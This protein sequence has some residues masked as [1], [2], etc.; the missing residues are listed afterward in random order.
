[1]KQTQEIQ[2]FDAVNQPLK[3]GVHLVEA[4]AGTGKTYAIAML[5]LRFIAEREL[6]IDR[7]LIVTYTRAATAELRARVRRR[8]VEGWEILSGSSGE[9]DPT[10]TA[11]AQTIPETERGQICLRLRLAIA[12]IDQAAIFTIHGFCQRM[13]MERA[14][15]SGGPFDAELVTDI[16]PVV[17]EVADDFWRECLYP[18]SGLLAAAVRREAKAPEQLLAT[19]RRSLRSGALLP[20]KRK[21]PA[22]AEAELDAEKSRFC[23]WWQQ[24]RDR[25]SRQ[26]EE[27]EAAGFFNAA[28]RDEWRAVGSACD[29]MA[30]GGAIPEKLHLFSAESLCDPGTK[31]LNRRRVKDAVSFCRERIFP[32]VEQLRDGERQLVLSVRCDLAGRLR[33]GVNR[34]LSERGWLSFDALINNLAEALQ[35]DDGRLLRHGLSQRFGAA[36]I[37]EFQDTDGEQYTIFSTLFGHGA[38]HLFL[39]GDPKQAIY[40]FRGADIHS[41]FAARRA[42]DTLLTLN[43]NYR[44]HPKVTAAI[45]HLFSGPPRPFLYAAEKLPFVPVESRDLSEC[46]HLEVGGE[47]ADGLEFWLLPEPPKKRWS[48]AAARAVLLRGVAAEISRLISEEAVIVDHE[49][50][51]PLLPGDIA[52]LVRTNTVATECVDTLADA[53]IPAVTLSRQSVWESEQCRQLLLVVQAILAPG[54]LGRFRAGLACGWFGLSGCDIDRI[55]ADEERLG[56]WRERMLGYRRRWQESSFFAMMV[57]LLHT[58]EVLQRLAVEKRGERM[59]AN[60][61]QLLGLA[62]EQEEARHLQPR[63]LLEWLRRSAAGEVR[64]DDELLLESDEDAV[65]VVTMHRA[66]GLEYGVVFCLDLWQTGDRLR[67]E[68]H[69]VVAREGGRTVID[70][71]SA[72]FSRHRRDA[73]LEAEA[74]A[75]RLL[76][77]AVTRARFRCCVP[78]VDCQGRGMVAD[79]LASP[80]AWLLFGTRCDSEGRISQISAEEQVA[81]LTE[82]CARS[83]ATLRRLEDEPQVSFAPPPAKKKALHLVETC[84]NPADHWQLTSFTSLAGLSESGH[85]VMQRE[86]EGDEDAALIPL[87]ALPAGPRFGNIIHGLLEELPFGELH[88]ERFDELSASLCLRHRVSV[89]TAQLELLLNNVVQTPLPT[90]AGN[91]FTLA[92]LSESACLKEMEFCMSL[93]DCTAAALSDL[94][95]T[96]DAAVS[97]LGD[98]RLAG[99]LSGFIDLICYHDGRYWLLDYKSNNLGPRRSSYRRESLLAAMRAHNYG[100]QYW[101]YTLVIHRWLRRRIPDYSYERHFGG[102]FYL[103]V[104]GM[105]PGTSDGVYST[106]PA[107][108]VVARFDELTGGG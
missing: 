16:D 1:M 78:W 2:I 90:A 65:Q 17:Q 11:W 94:L 73:T 108:E 54:D 47:P 60:I 49:R 56:A 72:E 67:R 8:L 41:Y 30:R 103:F 7:I 40:S 62:G 29:Q 21:S 37:D 53:G 36:L 91:T 34:R 25:F 28:L 100:L 70:L 77:V 95:T 27:D 24:N 13:L 6:E 10:L 32:P 39:I 59:I 58:E 92:G 107:A 82:H 31:L 14:L 71:G 63:E 12:N 76:Y 50:R 44:S 69:Q 5:V 61:R 48:S 38:H 81:A 102:V 22:A 43:K 93:G 64:G 3:P 45:N 86:V 9:F 96:A 35:G 33:A 52:I 84:R 18:A 88:G 89:D 20:E 83:G 19:V 104:R 74:E 57:E 106:R 66:K 87:P 55:N 98:R 99:F 4:S 105:Q 51:R 23:S 80:L 68:Q 97:P 15:E 46:D 75:L 42:A 26:Y 79:S 101:I 85:E